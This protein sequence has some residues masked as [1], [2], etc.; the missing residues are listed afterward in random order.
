MPGYIEDRW[1]RKKPDPKTGEMKKSTYGVGMRY[2]VCGI[3]GVKDESFVKLKDAKDWLASAQTDSR[4]GAYLDPRLGQ[5]TL[6][7]YIETV[8]W[9]GRSDELT[10]SGPMQSKVK[11]HIIPHLG[12]LP[13]WTITDEHLRLWV[14]T[15][16]AKP[17]AESTIETIWIHLTG[18][19]KTAVGKRIP[20]NPCSEMGADRPAGAGETKAR[21]W[22]REEVVGIRA[23]LPERYR[24]TVDLGV[25]AGLRQGEVM[26]ISPDDIDEAAGFLHIRRQLQWNSSKAY[27]KLPKGKKE[28]DV[29]LSP[30]LLAALKAHLERF[31]PVTVTLPWR[32]PGN[33]NKPTATVSLVVT[34][35]FKNPVHNG[36]FNKRAWKGA[37]AIVGLIAPRDASTGGSGWEP[38]RDLMFH[39]CRHTYASVQLGGR[40]NPLSVSQWMGHASPDITFRIYA[41]FMPG[42]REQGRKAVDAWLAE[43]S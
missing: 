16:R 3:P 9:P 31:P 35:F 40:E 10:T 15:L 5:I 26:A 27:F 28:R 30:G 19:L 14:A 17:L 39:R 33:A 23:A 7:E 1:M 8:Y 43:A 41:H 32:G 4:R 22:T 2:R 25:G 6:A 12:H 29:P 20:K 24:V 37:L 11:N 42:H 34:T 38:S 13:L 36:S 21:A 18:I